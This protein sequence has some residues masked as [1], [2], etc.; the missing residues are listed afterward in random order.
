MIIVARKRHRQNYCGL[1]VLGNEVINEEEDISSSEI[2]VADGDGDLAPLT[3]IYELLM[4]SEFTEIQIDSD[5]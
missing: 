2:L 3:N 1:E 4:N 5:D